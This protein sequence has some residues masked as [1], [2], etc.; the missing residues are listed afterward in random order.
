VLHTGSC[1]RRKARWEVECEQQGAY[2]DRGA[3]SRAAGQRGDLGT[4]PPSGGATQEKEGR[5]HW[6]GRHEG[7][8]RAQGMRDEGSDR[9][10]RGS[11][12]WL[13]HAQNGGTSGW[14]SS[15]SPDCLQKKRDWADQRVPQFS[16]Q[17]EEGRDKER[18]KRPRVEI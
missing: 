8:K 17:R 6:P 11:V 7:G 2:D 10:C 3:A 13:G 18:R 5:Q 4:R 9:F 14:D 16:E 15:L 1:S 12:T